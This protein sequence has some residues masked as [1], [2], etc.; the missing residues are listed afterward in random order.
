MSRLIR[1]IGIERFQYYWQHYPLLRWAL[2]HWLSWPL[3]LFAASLL[4]RVAGFL[5][6]LLAGAVVGAI[7]GGGQAYLL[8]D[9]FEE[10]RRWTLYSAAGALIGSY[11]AYIFLF[12][13][14]LSW[15]IA[16]L[17]VGLSFGFAFGGMQAYALYRAG[18]RSFLRWFGM[19]VLAAL[20]GTW[21][22]ALGIVIGWP[23]LLSPSGILF[24]VALGYSQEK[25]KPHHFN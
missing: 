5:G 8:Y 3:G 15:W 16:A 9:N 10:R 19:S 14:L 24:G 2:I 20:L 25:R 23:M 4:V 7:V 21:L 18:N 6:I 22:A 12:F 11:P 1:E 13:G 17:F